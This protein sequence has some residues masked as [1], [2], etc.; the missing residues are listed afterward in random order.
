MRRRSASTSSGRNRLKPEGK[1]TAVRTPRFAQ[2]RMVGSDT[3]SLWA[4]SLTFKSC[5]AMVP[6]YHFRDF[7]DNLLCPRSFRMDVT[8]KGAALAVPVA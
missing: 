5:W 8:C 4:V 3:P 2:L 7:F 1:R 6:A